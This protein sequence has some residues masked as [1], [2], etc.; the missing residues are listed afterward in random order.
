MELLPTSP[1]L[2]QPPSATSNIYCISMLIAVCVLAVLST[3]P[4]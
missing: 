1:L 4:T 3:S 2:A